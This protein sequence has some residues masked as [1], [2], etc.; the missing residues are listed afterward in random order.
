MSI[1][2]S[3]VAIDTKI[4]CIIQSY[5]AARQLSIQTITGVLYVVGIVKSMS[6]GDTVHYR[7]SNSILFINLL[8]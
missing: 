4:Y 2:L 3:M 8:A 1:T 7:I 5:S 6:Q